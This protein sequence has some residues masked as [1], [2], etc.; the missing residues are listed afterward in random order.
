ML[1]DDELARELGA[2]FREQAVGITYA[3]RRRPPSRA[4][5][6]LSAAA[7]AIALGAGLGMALHPS[8]AAPPPART[9][10]GPSSPP[11]ARTAVSATINL[12]GFILHYQKPAGSPPQLRVVRA[13]RGLPPRARPVPLSG[14]TAKAWVGTDPASSDN[15]IYLRSPARNGGRLFA[16]LSANWTQRQ[17]IALLRTGTTSPGVRHTT[18]AP[19]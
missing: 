10:A 11:A 2:L 18:P 1:T 17:L 6:A 12:D 5:A 4:A 8:P 3:G 19:A 13:V 14:T 15:A 16:I 7:A 9:A